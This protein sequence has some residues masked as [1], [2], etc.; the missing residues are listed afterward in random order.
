MRLQD[1]LVDAGTDQLSHTKLWNNIANAVATYVVLDLHREGKLS[2]DW[3]L[4]YLAVVG[5][6][7][8]LSKWTSLKFGASAAEKAAG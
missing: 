5:G 3:M 1:I 4:L 8:V 2:I 7:A 6:V